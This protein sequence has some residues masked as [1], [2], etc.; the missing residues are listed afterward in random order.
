MKVSILLMRPS[1][2][3]YSLYEIIINKG[4][5]LV[6]S[7]RFDEAYPHSIAYID[8]LGIIQ[9]ICSHLTNN[10]YENNN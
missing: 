9:E 10:K 3:N 6:L 4:I 5:P 8:K 2:T 1:N 7:D